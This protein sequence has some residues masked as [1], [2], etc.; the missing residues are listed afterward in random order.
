M[1]GGKGDEASKRLY[2]YDVVSRCAFSMTVCSTHS[3]NGEFI[4][5]IEYR[6]LSYM[7]VGRSIAACKTV[8]DRGDWLLSETYNQNE[9]TG[10]S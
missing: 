1:T 4:L 10:G 2:I 5:K 7:G 8:D 9:D 6:W 3:L